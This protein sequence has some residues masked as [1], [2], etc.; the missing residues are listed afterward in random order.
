MGAEK[1]M[2]I[3]YVGHFL[4]SGGYCT[5][6]INYIE[7][8]EKAGL[9]V[10]AIPFCLTKKTLEMSDIIKK[11]Y[12]RKLSNVDLVILHTLPEFFSRHPNLPTIGIF[13]SEMSGIPKKWVE[14]INKLDYCIVSSEQS[15]NACY[16]SGVSIK[17]D[18]IPY[19]I[20]VKKYGENYDCSDIIN[21]IKSEGKS[22]FYTVGEFVNRK[23][24]SSLLRAYYTEFSKGDNVHLVIKS[25]LN[26]KTPQETANIFQMKN[27]EIF[28]GL[29]LPAEN[30]PE[31]TFLPSEM[32]E[33][34]ILSLHQHSDFYVCASYGESWSLP[35]FDA[36]AFGKTPIVPNSTG[37]LEYM[38]DNE[39][40]MVKTFE[41]PCFGLIDANPEI[42]NSSF[43]YYQVD[44]N[45]MRNKMRFC[46]SNKDR[47]KEKS[48]AGMKKSMLYSHEN[49][50]PQLRKAIENVTK[51]LR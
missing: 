47:L 11:S 16:S 27:Y 23:N 28:K 35:S 36:M 1:T 15:K 26:G 30:M 34:D 24:Y 29:N 48:I 43:N 40:F 5:A 2:K 22:V 31:V 39:G 42:Y 37:F 41:A 44:I 14:E 9:E 21:E 3:A 49:I 18:K 33:E 19:C 51:E 25:G 20:D 17:I 10:V 45:D 6:A 8:L 38:S 4:D 50:G 32:T 12:N 13:S 7:S 46:L